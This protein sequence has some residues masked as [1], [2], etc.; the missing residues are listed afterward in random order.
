PTARRPPWGRRAAPQTLNAKGPEDGHAH[1]SPIGSFSDGA[2]PYG[3]LDM[4][5]NVWEWVADSFARY[6]RAQ[7]VDPLC[8][9]GSRKVIRGSS[10]QSAARFGYAANRKERKGSDRRPEIGFR[11]ARSAR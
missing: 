5:G 8:E 1:T 9:E 4:V 7:Q 11:V 6:P 3:C 2:S 10:W